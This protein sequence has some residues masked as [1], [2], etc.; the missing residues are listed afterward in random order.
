MQTNLHNGKTA[1]IANANL[2]D[3]KKNKK[4]E[5]YTQLSAIEMSQSTT[6]SISKINRALQ[7]Q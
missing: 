6:K 4:D 5:F 1:K 2:H 3:A 7:L